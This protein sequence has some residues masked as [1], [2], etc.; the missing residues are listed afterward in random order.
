MSGRLGTASLA[1]TT[2]TTV[3][4]VPT[5]KTS[6]VTVNFCNTTS[7]AATVR[8]ALALADTPV[9]GEWIEYDCSLPA[10]GV[11]ERGGIVLGEGQRIVAYA[12]ATGININVWGFEE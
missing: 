3:Y 1:A 9:A 7:A 10:N 5:G 4:A 8:L 6:T 12:S 2:N 11:L